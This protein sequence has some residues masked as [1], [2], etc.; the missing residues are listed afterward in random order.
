MI[1]VFNGG[2]QPN[3]VFSIFQRFQYQN[4]PRFF[5]A[6]KRKKGDG[7][8]LLRFWKERLKIGVSDWINAN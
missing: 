8:D 7:V 5:I 3:P 6:L 4:N 1:E 2:V